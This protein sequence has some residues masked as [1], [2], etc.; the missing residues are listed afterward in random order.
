M[1]TGEGK[2]GSMSE[3]RA[4][5]IRQ[6]DLAE[7]EADAA[8]LILLAQRWYRLVEESLG[9]DGGQSRDALTQLRDELFAAL[10]WVG[11]DPRRVSGE[12]LSASLADAETLIL[13]MA[14]HRIRAAS[15]SETEGSP[16]PGRS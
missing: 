5:R 16:E 13:D 2:G 8:D 10:V 3:D 1:E 14:V 6:L 12:G 11:D 15:L 4:G 7:A 9:R